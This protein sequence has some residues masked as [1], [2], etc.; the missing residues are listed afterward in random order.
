MTD[1]PN[2]LFIIT[3][4]QRADWL[5]CAGHPV[6]RT[7]H[8]D[9]IAARGTRFD[10]FHVASPVCMP[11]RASLMT[12]RYP[13]LH[14]LRYNGCALPETANTCADVLSA[15]GYHTALIGK[16][17]LQPFTGLPPMG[18]DAGPE[19][20]LIDEAW[21]AS[22]PETYAEEA[23]RFAGEARS[24]MATPYYGFK[25][26]DLVT[27]HGD[28]CGGHYGQWFRATAPDWKALH[29]PANELLHGYTCPQAYRT[30]IPE[31]LYPTAYV[32]D[33]AVE[34]LGARAGRDDPFL[35]FVSFP[36]PHHPFNPPGTYWDLYDPDDFEVGLPF[37]AHANP[38]PPMRWLHDS[39]QSGGGQ[40]TPQTAMMLG[41]KQ[42]REAMALTA[43]MI[44]CIDDAVGEILAAL[45]ANGQL[46][47][48]VIV[49]T[50]DHGD[51][52]GDF[53]M[54]LKGALPFR[55]IT[56][57]PFLWSDP[58][59]RVGATSEALCSSVDLSATILERAEL[60]PFNGNQGQSFL[61]AIH[62]G[63]GPRAEALI[64]YNDGGRR[65]GFESPARVRSVVTHEWRYT[66]YRDQDWG[67]LYHL[68]ED[69]GETRNLWDDPAHRAVRA[70]MAERL[71]HLL[72]AQMDESPLSDRIA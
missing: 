10:Q 51:Y 58:A 59:H 50:S 36:D 31:D 9:S 16:S 66:L 54:I 17:H 5:G 48:T 53:N 12:G 63:E 21:R 14:G 30:P 20:R 6:V 2:F 68:A 64:E 8:I 26:V 24:E 4:Q 34:Y 70:E 3:D 44:S 71:N 65:L 23:P 55:S 62:G 43:G 47:N 69:P 19:G 72:I 46:E 41:E 33:R 42:I 67:E 28:K 29:D 11:N 7:P 22:R 61:D 35:A 37:E 25:H 1:R 13:S 40:T 52:L 57:V 38:T 45:E 60:A 18:R 27:H 56:R 15:A 32:R 49:F 39:W